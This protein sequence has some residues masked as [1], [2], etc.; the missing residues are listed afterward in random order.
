MKAA[1]AGIIQ[2]W[3]LTVNVLAGLV[4]GS[5]LMAAVILAVPSASQPVQTQPSRTITDTTKSTNDGQKTTV[6]TTHTAVSNAPSLLERYLA[7]GRLELLVRFGLA[8][9]AA[10]L[11]GAVVQRTLLGQY[12]ITLPFVT[13]PGVSETAASSAQAIGQ[14]SDSLERQ[15]EDTRTALTQAADALDAAAL[16]LR[17]VRELRRSLGRTD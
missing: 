10:F 4:A 14:V 6:E 9:I 3:R 11:A 7:E 12:A 2:H 8:T 5:V 15:A 16:A 1:L 13:V 17:E